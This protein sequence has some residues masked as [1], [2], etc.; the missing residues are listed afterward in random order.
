[1][2]VTLGFPSSVFP[3]DAVNDRLPLIALSD[4]PAPI[5]KSEVQLYE[6]KPSELVVWKS[7]ETKSPLHTTKSSGCIMSADGLTIIENCS[8]TPGHSES[9]FSKVGVTSIIASNWLGP[10]LT[11]INDGMKSDPLFVGNPISSLD[12]RTCHK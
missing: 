11:G 8:E 10:P 6:V 2:A 4:V 9:S 7:T 12:E 5:S 1:M 3:L